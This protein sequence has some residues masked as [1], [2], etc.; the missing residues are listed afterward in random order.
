MTFVFEP[1]KSLLIVAA[2]FVV[3]A[4]LV[5]VLSN[6]NPARKAIGLLIAVALAGVM[7]LRYR[8]AELTVDDVGITAGTYG[9]PSI[10]W[11]DVEQAAYV[12]NL[13][14]SWYVPTPKLKSAFRL[15]GYA[16]A[17]YGWFDAN[18]GRPAL[19]AVQ[20]YDGDAVVV[21]TADTT[22]VF[23]PSDTVGLA[24]AIAQFVPVVGLEDSR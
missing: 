2:I 5:L 6:R 20:Q 8:T 11:A 4:I 22:Y 3:A 14:G 18:G 7:L 15:L 10:Q 24:Q 23:G 17:R 21:I 19:F 9:K 16:K 12:A 1:P 13:A